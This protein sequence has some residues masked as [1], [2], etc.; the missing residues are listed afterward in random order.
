MTRLAAFAIRACPLQL[1]DRLF[2]SP[3]SAT[4]R[5]QRASVKGPSTLMALRTALGHGCRLLASGPRW[6]FLAPGICHARS[7]CAFYISLSLGI[8]N[9]THDIDTSPNGG[10]GK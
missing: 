1:R 6:L 5:G 4:S 10:F 2:T 8:A 3:P 9:L 7:S